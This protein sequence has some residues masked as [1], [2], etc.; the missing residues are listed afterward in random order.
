VAVIAEGRMIV[1][2]YDKVPLADIELKS[3]V[4]LIRV[5]NLNLVAISTQVEMF[6]FVSKTSKKLYSALQLIVSQNK[7][8]EELLVSA[9]DQKYWLNGMLNLREI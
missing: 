3:V 6:V 9:S 5:E 4:K 1:L 7:R 2:S 8:M